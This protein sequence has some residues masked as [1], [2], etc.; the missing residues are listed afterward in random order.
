MTCSDYHATPRFAALLLLFACAVLPLSMQVSAQSPTAQQSS[1]T[2]EML[3]NRIQEIELSSEL[4]EANKSGLLDLYRRSV[5]LLEQ[6]RGYEV[7][8]DEFVKARGRR[9]LVWEGPRLGEG[10]HKV[11]TD[12]IHFNWRTVDFPAQEMLDA[13][14]EVVHAAW[15]PLYIVDHYPRTMFTAVSVQRCYEWDVRRFAHVNHGM[16][17]F[18]DPHVTKT[19]D[20][21]LGFCMPWWEGRPE[22]LMGLCIPR[23]AAVA[24]AAWHRAGERDF[25][26]FQQRQAR[27]LPRLEIVAGFAFPRLPYADPATQIDNLAYRAEVAV[28]T[29]ASQPVFGPQRLT[30]GLTDRFDHFLGYPT[31][32]ERLEIVVDLGRVATVARVVVHET[33]VGES[34]EVYDVSVSTDAADYVEVGTAGEGSRG[35]HAFVEHTFEARPV[36]FVRIRT[37]GCHGLTFPSFSRLTEVMVFGQ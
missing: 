7:A 26:A 30:N 19:A 22:N 11:S 20:G 37:L 9:T 15:D 5:S 34:H 18:A 4:D 31:R 33:A 24:S 6:R 14:Y 23:L 3:E 1:I 25:A 12:V 35:E 32:P 13:G 2:Q 36:R 8:T 28:S 29:G 21:I 16:P 17:T 10:E 27:L